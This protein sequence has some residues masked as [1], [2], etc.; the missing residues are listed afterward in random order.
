M[1]CDRQLNASVATA[2]PSRGSEQSLRL[3]GT[4][5]RQQLLRTYGTLKPIVPPFQFAPA[6]LLGTYSDNEDLQ[7][8]ADQLGQWRISHKLSL[9]RCRDRSQPCSSHSSFVTAALDCNSI[10]SSMGALKPRPS[11]SRKCKSHAKPTA[12]QGSTTR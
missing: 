7:G 8:V 12:N 4:T 2:A 11:A 1:H 3:K 5:S 10:M 6:I 9:A